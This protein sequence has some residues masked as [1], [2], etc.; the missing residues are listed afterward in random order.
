MIYLTSFHGQIITLKELTLDKKL[1]ASQC[2]IS[3][4]F[5]V[6]NVH[7]ATQYSDQFKVN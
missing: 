6:K 5:N 4:D 2:V 1:D 3:G 7:F